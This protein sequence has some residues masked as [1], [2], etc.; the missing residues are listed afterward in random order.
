MIV[1]RQDG[2]LV[3]IRQLDHSA[4][5]GEFT[6]HWGNDRFEHPTP[7]E[8]VVLASARHDEGWREQDEKPLFDPQ[9]K[10]PLH[11][12]DIDVPE[13]AVFYRAG[14]ERVIALDPYAGLL[15]SMHASGFYTRRYGTFQV[16]MTKIT[17]AVRPVITEF[18]THQE[19]VQA[20]LK[21]RI[22]D[23]MQRR[24]EFERRLWAHYELLQVWDRLS[25]FVCLNDLDR[26]AEDRLGPLPVTTD[27]PVV[28]LSV[29]ARGNGIVALD[30]YPFDVPVLD[31]SVPAR[32]IPD[33]PVEGPDELRAV[34]REA[35]DAP[36]RC[37]FV[38][39]T[40]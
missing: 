36:I 37:R 10:G 35:R 13:H 12:R 14:I 11:F 29:Q 34:L 24:S 31:A 4:L 39:A 33:R 23:P 22:W 30:P 32:T 21:R 1:R 8:A 7:D 17:D 16:K 25:L 15:V 27:G 3:L 5:S 9:R 6:R 26:P 19:M 18:V 2:L 20:A 40:G 38:P 28:E